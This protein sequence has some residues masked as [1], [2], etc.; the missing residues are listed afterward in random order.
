MKFLAVLLSFFPL[1]AMADAAQ[2][3]K[4]RLDDIQSIQGRFSQSLR[5]KAGKEMQSTKGEFAVK[6]P[7][8]FLWESEAPYEQTVIGTPEKVWVYDPDLEQVTVRNS[9]KEIGNNPARLL[10]GDLNEIRSTYEVTQQVGESTDL[11]Q[12]VPKDS[13]SPYSHVEFEFNGRQLSGLNFKDKLDQRTLIVFDQ[14]QLNVEIPSSVF[15]FD[16]PEGT[17]VIVDE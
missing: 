5:D 8:Y 15:V 14:V 12:L 4:N 11:F 17:D 3:L 6:R 16:P 1:F 13:S 7:G 9:Q 10:S 2:D